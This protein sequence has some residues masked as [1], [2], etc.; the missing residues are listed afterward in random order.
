[1][2][3]QQASALI[4]V[5]VCSVYLARQAYVSIKAFFSTKQEGCGS[6]CGKCAFAQQHKATSPETRSRQTIKLIPLSA[7]RS[8]SSSDRRSGTDL[9][10][11]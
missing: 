4:I 9:E 10:S 1:M 11:K 7:V 3:V 8:H 2:S 5:A 6:G